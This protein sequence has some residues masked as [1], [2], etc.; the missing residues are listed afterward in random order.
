[1]ERK[2]KGEVES[3][4]DEAKKEME[5]EFRVLEETVKAMEMGDNEL[6]KRVA[7]L[8][9]KTVADRKEYSHR[10]RE[11]RAE[12]GKEI[13]ELLSQLDMVEA[14]HNERYKQKD[15][16]MK[17]KDTVISALGSQLADAQSRLGANHESQESLAK[18]LEALRENLD[19]A[20]AEI[21]ARNQDIVRLVAEHQRG[22]DAEMILREE[23][24]ELA[25]EEMIERAEVQFQ[26]ANATYKKLKHEF[27]SATSKIATL[28][29]DVRFAKKE[30]AEMKKR[31]E[32][33]E[34]DLADELAQ[35][36]S[37]KEDK[38]SVPNHDLLLCDLHSLTILRSSL[39][40]QPLRQA[41]LMLRVR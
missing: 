11:V 38:R 5:A 37:G 36:K 26:Q 7:E 40:T 18:E 4:K 24:I 6:T 32:G 2:H 12:H 10:V 15:K 1:M 25:R 17:E 8:Q 23:A 29:R 39:E 3:A 31:Q 28:E 20:R 14:E 13:E 22:I 27:D 16:Y 35:A 30:A 41:T 33:R 34:V 19:M 21:E 9:A